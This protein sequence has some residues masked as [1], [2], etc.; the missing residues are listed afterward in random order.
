MG[1]NNNI[2]LVFDKYAAQYNN[3]RQMLIPCFADFYKIA[4]EIIPF[5]EDKNI[6]VLDLGAGTGLISSLVATK[7]EKSDITLVDVSEKMLDQAKNSLGKL[8]NK[9]SYLVTNYSNLELS[10]S[11]DVVIS[12]LSIHHLTGEEKKSLFKKIFTNLNNGGIFINA[13]QVQGETVEIETKYREVW[14]RQVQENGIGKSELEAALERMKE[15]KMSPL[16]SQ[17]QWLNEAGFEEVNCWYKNY[18]FV[19]YS[20]ICI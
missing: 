9:F 17:L 16:S 6:K 13:D 11:F 2:K 7:Y 18:S 14:L 1:T 5:K 12:A 10:G 4:V 15:D 3:S 20:G 8:S 19:V